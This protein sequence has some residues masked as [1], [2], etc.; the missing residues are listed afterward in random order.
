MV[1]GDQWLDLWPLVDYGLAT[2][3]TLEGVRRS[4][5]S[6]PQVYFRSEPD[7]LLYAALAGDIPIGERSD[8]LDSFQ[9]LFRIEEPINS[10]PPDDYE[11][12]IAADSE[13][14]VGRQKE[15]EQA[16]AAI[17]DTQQ[18][19]LWIS[20]PGGIGKSFLLARLAHDLRG[21]PRKTCRIAWRFRA[22]DQRRCNRIAFFRHAVEQL[23]AW[24][25][26]KKVISEIEQPD[27][28]PIKLEKQ[29][30]DLLD[31][32]AALPAPSPSGRPPRLLIVLDGLDEI[33]RQDLSF[34]HRPFDLHR[35]NVVWLCAG[36]AE[37]GLENIFT[38]D[39]CRHIFDDGLPP[40]TADDIRAMLI[41][42]S[43]LL[44]YEFLVMD[45]ETA[46]P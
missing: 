26:E 16:K 25:F 4:S 37:G 14:L 44:K 13:L 29:F 12:E 24:L 35:S 10:A 41:E 39:R 9:K 11:Q 20:G 18:G 21:D 7:R 38:P 30:I 45:R 15:I 5:E 8:V 42:G 46:Q 31:R 17:K 34:A 1:R 19:V 32:T 33:A 36:R 2:T 6:S 40:M 22:S 27:Q 43:G 28:D 3:H 23:S